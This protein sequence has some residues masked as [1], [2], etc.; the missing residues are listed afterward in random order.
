MKR[1]VATLLSSIALVSAAA[2]ASA[3]VPHHLAKPAAKV[4]TTPAIP[5]GPPPTAPLALPGM[6]A[7]PELPAQASYVLMDAKTGAV[8]AEKAP[9]LAWPPASLTKLMTAYLVYQAIAHGT[10]KM[11]QTVPVSDAAWHTG[12]SRMFISPGMT[13][14]VD[15]LLHGLIIDSGNDAAVALAQAVAGSRS[16]FVGL[17]NHEAKVLH[18]DRTHYVNVDGLPDPTLRTTAMDVAK[19][20]RAIVTDYPQYL[21]ISVLKHYTFDKIRQRSWNPVLFRDPTVDGLKTGRTNEAGH[22]I[23]ATALRDGRRLIAVVLGGPN[24]V[25]STNDIESLLDYGYQF[26]TDATVVDAGKTLGSMPTPGYQQVS[27]PVAAQHDVVMTVPKVAVK[28]FKT[29]VTY[30]APP[31]AGVAKGDVVG[32]ITVSADGKTIATVPAVAMVADP[33]AGFMTRMVRRIKHA[34]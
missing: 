31:K 24:W 33:E 6:A 5:A 21:K 15:Q 26:Y 11:D 13:V 18:L 23:D 20:S 17:M 3:A 2:P 28:G 32:T 27:V 7:P 1:S 10:L 9:D 25:T 14:T 4:A 30:D 29:T 34:L 12:G 8:I 19:L 22:C 16:S